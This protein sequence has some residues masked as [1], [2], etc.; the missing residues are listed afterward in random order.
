MAD[1]DPQD[2]DGIIFAT[3]TPDSTMPTCACKV[4]E[5]LNIPTKF[6]F[7]MQAACTGF[8]Y[9]CSTANAMIVAGQ[10][11][12]ILVIGA[13]KLTATVD[14]TDRGTCILFGDGAGAA[15]IE[16]S[17][18]P[19]IRSV[20]TY[21]DGQYG[22]LLELEGIGTDFLE[23]RKDWDIETKLLKMKGNEIFKIAVRN[24]SEAALTAVKSSGLSTDEIDY[25]VPHQ[26]NLRIIDATAKRLK[27]PSDK[28]VI[29]L[30]K[31]GNTS[32][33]TIPTAL[34]GA[35]RDGRIK[36]GSNVACA[37]FGGGLT[38][39]SMVFTF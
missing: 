15:I 26:A 11:E 3:F 19:G 6:A 18:T 25:L 20:H 39:G 33:A 38:W 23:H 30:H 34:D 12:K 16:K 5:K 35:V 32:A 8:I 28:V 21:A 29:N 2:L 37:A 36:E 24:M 31:Y 13:D 1:V 4:Q 9:A 17:A 27:L 10:A 22:R 14:W 7:D